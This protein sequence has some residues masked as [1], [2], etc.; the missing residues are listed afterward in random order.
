[1]E[2][3]FENILSY[4]KLGWSSRQIS[5]KCSVSHTTINKFLRQNGLRSNWDRC[6]PIEMVSKDKARCKKCRIIYP[7]REFQYGRRGQKYE[8]RYSFCNKCR[9]EKYYFDSNN[10]VEKFLSR[11]FVITKKR[12]HNK[13]SKF[14]LTKDY[15][16]NLYKK[17][18]GLC[19]Y[20]GVKLECRVGEGISRNSF[21]VDKIIPEEGYVEGNV[22]FC[23]F[24][25][26][27][28]KNDWS[29]DEMRIWMPSWYEKIMKFLAEGSYPILTT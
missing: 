8:Y 13:G 25:A 14:L 1:M 19:F 23:S 10:S 6:E 3:L 16:I 22:V 15:F 28:S 2:S 5:K 21:S 11:R 26:N 24:R 20:T 4:H 27:V 12:A 18:E 17:Q 7:L 9:R 29:L